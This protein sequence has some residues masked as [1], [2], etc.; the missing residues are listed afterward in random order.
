MSDIAT[1][2]MLMGGPKPKKVRK[3]PRAAVKVGKTMMFWGT[4]KVLITRRE[5]KKIFFKKLDTDIESIESWSTEIRD[6]TPM[7]GN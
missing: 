1:L 7:E 2:A 4:T 6:F 3:T 5:G